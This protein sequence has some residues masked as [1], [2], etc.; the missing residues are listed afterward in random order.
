[1]NETT[2]A[3]INDYF[4]ELT[5]IHSA[6]NAMAKNEKEL[7]QDYRIE[8]ALAALWCGIEDLGQV[9]ERKGLELRW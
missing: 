6:L 5:K 8:N 9:L 7:A 4:A 3:A 2:K 1:M